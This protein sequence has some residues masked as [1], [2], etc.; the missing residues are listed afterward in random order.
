MY[1][2]QLE[3]T[4]YRNHKNLTL[5]F[6]DKITLIT[7]ENGSGKTNIIEAINL[8]STGKGFKAGFDKET[9]DY[10][11]ETATIKGLIIKE[12]PNE[13]KT[14]LRIGV[15]IQK[16]NE[17]GNKSSKTVK[18][19]G[20][21]TRI[22]A[23][24]NN[25]NTVLFSPLEMN[26]LVNGPS[27]RRAFL[28]TLLSQGDDEYKRNLS[29]Y[30]KVRRQ[31]N[32]VLENIRETGAGYAQL[33][34]WNERLIKRGEA[35]QA[36]RKDFFEHLN[37]NINKVIQKVDPKIE[38][39]VK[40]IINP[41]IE[42]KL[43]FYEPREVAAATTLL[44]PHR[45]D[46][47]FTSEKYGQNQDLSKYASRG[48]QRTLILSLKLCELNY[49][50]KKLVEKPVL[51]LDDIFSELDENHKNALEKVIFDQQTIITSTEKPNSYK[52]SPVISL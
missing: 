31:R 38:T 49:L 2:K 20:K 39:T 12:A 8:L 14:E 40:Y 50:E 15:M 7:G 34:F 27:Q 4:N 30:I 22:G 18:I 48:Q 42:E 6:S 26:L 51:L 3:L 28:D 52:N 36:K 21:S 45:D 37:K 9:I 5:E 32:K 41:A 24:S 25:F 43:A 47:I 13:V 16:L 1:I 29:D 44:G 46:F 35:I 23:L 17:E 33:K 19:N 11:K 10:Q